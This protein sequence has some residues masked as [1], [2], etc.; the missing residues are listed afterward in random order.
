[1]A[2]CVFLTITT[3]FSSVSSSICAR[4]GCIYP[5]LYTRNSVPVLRAFTLLQAS[6]TAH[7]DATAIS[8]NRKLL[9]ATSTSLAESESIKPHRQWDRRSPFVVY[10][11]A[12][13]RPSPLHFSLRSASSAE[14][15][16][17]NSD[18]LSHSSTPD[19]KSV[20]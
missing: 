19:R 5:F 13:D 16:T 3:R 6:S 10:H 12:R 7:A 14:W 4:I 9:R 15:H 8:R 11:P 2:V 20:V 1:M 17:T 18:A